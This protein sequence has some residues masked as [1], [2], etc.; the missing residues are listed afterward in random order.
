M[1]ETHQFAAEA[2]KGK[3]VPGEGCAEWRCIWWTGAVICIQRDG[4][5]FRL[6]PSGQRGLRRGVGPWDSEAC[7]SECIVQTYRVLFTLLD[8]LATAISVFAFD[9]CK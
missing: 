6:D 4:N 5:G 1:L 8:E 7:S 2:G 9:T 3:V